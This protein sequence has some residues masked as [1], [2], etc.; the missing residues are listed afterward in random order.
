M[1]DK[2]LNLQNKD[3]ILRERLAIER[4]TMANDTTLLAFIRTALYFY[5]A[6]LSINQLLRVQY[7]LILEVGFGVIAL[8]ILIVGI[9]KYRQQ[10][11]KLRES[12]KQIGNYKL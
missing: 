6:G 3:L 2:Q 10:N 1:E 11:A 5:V 4:T 8:I 7:G 9:F 12:E